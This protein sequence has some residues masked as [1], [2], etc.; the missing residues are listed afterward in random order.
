MLRKLLSHRLAKDTLILFGVQISGYVLPLI[1]L[2]FLTRV[3]GPANFGL[4]A[5]GTAL[6]LYF[7]VVVEWG[8][9]VTGT[10][11]IA[12]VQEDLAQVSRVYSTIM[13]CKLILLGLCFVVMVGF[14]AEVP[15]FRAYWPLYAVSYLQVIG[16]C[17]SPN[18]L[19]QGMQRMRYIAYSDYGAKIL[20]VILIFTFVRRSAD[21][22][23]VAAL[24]S[25]GFLISAMIGLSI[26]FF[27]LRLRIVRPR[28]ADMR[29]EMIS[30]WPVFLSM[31]SMTAMSSTNTV[32]VGA[33]ASAAE[34]GFLSA[35]QRLIIAVRALTNPIT[36]AVYP[37]IS[38]MAARSQR[39]AL[40]FLRKQ[41]LWT[42]A[43]FLLISLGMLLFSPLAV[44]ILY[45]RKYAETAVLLRIMSLTPVLHA[46]AMCFGTYFMLGF[47]YQKE[48]S[49]IITR[50]V[51]LN[52]ILIFGLVKL[53]PPA[54]AVALS[55]V[56]TDLFSAA[57]SALFYRRTTAR[58]DRTPRGEEAVVSVE[59]D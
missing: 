55:T 25:G 47:G 40:A 1:T 44:S 20:S 16:F 51:V 12:I 18:W 54:R 9:A 56:L 30:G 49:K 36:T 43:P 3:L 34:V 57:S 13:A 42:S 35:A 46:V 41:L 2:P 29:T 26:V 28:F 31:A 5:L 14:V 52:F 38:K 10:R 45:G 6:V 23:L 15:K 11:Q 39:D 7:A 37:H 19:L 24:Q 33:L 17:L 32:I 58:M 4:T 59:S 53:M 8:F 21:Y 27:G 22:M 50:M 48:W